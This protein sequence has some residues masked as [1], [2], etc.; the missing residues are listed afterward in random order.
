MLSPTPFPHIP[1]EA[2][3]PLHLRTSTFKNNLYQEQNLQCLRYWLSFHKD[4][5]YF[6]TWLSCVQISCRSTLPSPQSSHSRN[7]PSQEVLLGETRSWEP[8]A[9]SWFCGW[10]AVGPQTSRLPCLG[11]AFLLWETGNNSMLHLVVVKSENK[12]EDNMR[13][14]RVWFGGSV[15]SWLVAIVTKGSVVPV[16]SSLPLWLMQEKVGLSLCVFLPLS[17]ACPVTF[18]GHWMRK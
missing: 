1:R 15:A 9:L 7:N 12:C 5:F 6:Q 10:F 8:R 14:Y 16:H 13:V 4:F 17:Q 11:L 3:P 18:H 2:V